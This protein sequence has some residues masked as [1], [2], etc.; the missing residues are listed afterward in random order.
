MTIDRLIQ[1]HQIFGTSFM[2]LSKWRNSPVN[3]CRLFYNLLIVLI[4]FENVIFELILAEP[5]EELKI[6][7]LMQ[8]SYQCEGI[9]YAV[10]IFAISVTFL[11][12]LAR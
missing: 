2:D 3:I 1:F 8:I 11:I 9:F 5:L 7:P 4:S 10:E 6:S 12:S